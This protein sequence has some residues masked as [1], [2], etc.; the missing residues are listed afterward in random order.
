[1]ELV[2]RPTEHLLELPID[3]LG[4]P[5]GLVER[6]HD[7][8]SVE[9]PLENLG[10]LPFGSMRRFK[11]DASLH[12]ALIKVRVQ[13]EQLVSLLIESAITLRE[14]VVPAAQDPETEEPADQQSRQGCDDEEA[15]EKSLSLD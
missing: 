8:N 12:D 1:M 4:L 5:G 2:A 9:D 10:L 7:R 13:L 11:L 15:I 6:D 14:R 3:A